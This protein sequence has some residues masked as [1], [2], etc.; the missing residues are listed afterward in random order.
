[1]TPKRVGFLG[2]DGFMA[3]DLIGPMDAFAVTVVDNDCGAPRPAYELVVIGLS[4]R[5]FEAESG[6]IVKPHKTLDNAPAL[7]TLI[8]PG[9]SGL[10]RP[11]TSAAISAWLQRRTGKIRRIAS[12][13]TGT[14]GLAAAGLLDGRNVTTHWRFAADLARKFPN[15]KV[16][17]NALFLKDG[18]FY[19]SAGVTA[20]IDLALAMIEEDYGPAAALAVARELVVYLKRPGGQEQYSEPLQFQT[21]SAD[22]F[23]DLAAWMTGHLREDLSVEALARRAC[24]SPR[25]FTRRFRQVFAA[26]PATFVEDLRLAEARRRLGTHTN[27]VAQVAASVGF[28]SADAFRRVFERRLGIAPT[29]YR[30]CFDAPE[31]GTRSLARRATRFARTTPTQKGVLP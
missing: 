8:I 19:T 23:A 21:N 28:N 4:H 17:P 10:R 29:A 18:I 14:F 2:F 9:G 26:T 13:C 24:L 1:M 6:L 31:Q 15:L 27:T 3:L 22:R 16:N 30:R 20:G 25:Q 5:P 11:A 7:D 12:V